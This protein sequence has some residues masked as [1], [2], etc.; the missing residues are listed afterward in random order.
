VGY[1]VLLPP[2]LANFVFR[3]M[4]V[5]MGFIRFNVM[6]NFLNETSSAIQANAELPSDV[7]ER[8]RSLAVQGA[9]SLRNLT[10]S[11]L[12]VD[13]ALLSATDQALAWLDL[14]TQLFGVCLQND[15]AGEG[16]NNMDA[17]LAQQA[18]PTVIAEV[19]PVPGTDLRDLA[20]QYYGNP[21][22]WRI[23]GCLLQ[24]KSG[25]CRFVLH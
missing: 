11:I 4:Y 15:A 18:K 21:D 3:K 17:A 1:F 6:V 22:L 2:L 25:R 7:L 16:A 12:D 13:D 10:T 24:P 19:R 14:K 5:E 9:S 23:V 20:R 8:G